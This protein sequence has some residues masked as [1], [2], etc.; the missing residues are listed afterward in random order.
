MPLKLK[1]FT[2]RVPWSKDSPQEGEQDCIC[3]FCGTVIGVPD[4][5]PR[6]EGHDADCVGCGLC[7]V[8]IRMWRVE[9]KEMEEIRF[10]T[11]C[12]QRCAGTEIPLRREAMPLTR[13]ATEAQIH[14]A[15]EARMTTDNKTRFLERRSLAEKPECELNFY[16]FVCEG[17]RS[18]VELGLTPGD[19][20]PFVCPEGCGARYVQWEPVPGR[21]QLKCVVCPVFERK[22]EGGTD[23]AE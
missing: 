22:V 10:H 3:C 14:R 19:M 12:L 21:P 15:G 23:A 2:L 5:D 1:P 17:C 6:L 9:G 18:E 16:L 4:D 13:E 7:D 20:R 11:T 8:A